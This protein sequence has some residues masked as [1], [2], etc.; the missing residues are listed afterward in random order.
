MAWNKSEV[1]QQGAKRCVHAKKFGGGHVVLLATVL[2]VVAVAA[3]VFAVALSRDAAEDVVADEKKPSR[4]SVAEVKLSSSPHETKDDAPTEQPA[5]NPLVVAR[6]EKLKAMTPA[7]RIEFLFKEAEARPINLEPASN[8]VYATG[9]EQVLD[10]VFT[11]ELGDLPPILPSIPMYEEAHLVEILV[12]KNKT[13]ET[14][15]ERTANG[16]QMV[17]L[18]KKELI[19]YISAGGDVHGFLRYYHDQLRQAHMQRQEA[20]QSLFRLVREEPE[21]AREYLDAVNARLDEKGI[22]HVKIPPKL[23]ERYGIELD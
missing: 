22:K 16:K 7:E 9:T 8:R 10:W 15:D 11:T 5:E 2:A 4:I 1:R 12:N 21:L 20:Q 23:A 3:L 19:K 13:L 18:A 17:D 14:D 6:R